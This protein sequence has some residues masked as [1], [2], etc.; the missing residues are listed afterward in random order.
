MSALRKITAAALAA[1]LAAACDSEQEAAAPP[2]SRYEAVTLKSE[3]GPEKLAGFCDVQTKRAVQLPQLLRVPPDATKARWVNVWATWCQSCVEE[4]PMIERWR[5]EEGFSVLYISADEEPEA[6]AAFREGHP[7]TPASAEMRE[8]EQI[9]EWMRQLG[10]DAG[11][12]LPLHVFI[13][14]SG[15][16]LCARAAAV[17]AHHL[18][19]V[20]A[21]LQ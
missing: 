14:P 3:I 19:L 10:L 5:K 9:H 2:P 12:G 17:S 18:P 6:L 1:L 7:E 4:L 20:R 21:L 16:L 15:D 13:D 11:A 8:P